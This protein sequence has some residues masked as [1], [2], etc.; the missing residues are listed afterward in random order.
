MIP[1]AES[2]VLHHCVAEEL[3]IRVLKKYTNFQP[4]TIIVFGNQRLSFIADIP[5][6][7]GNKSA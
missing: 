3:V 5:V 2:D 4:G 6:S 7:R 1:E